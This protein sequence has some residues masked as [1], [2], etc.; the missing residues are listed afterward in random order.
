M[1][2]L[3]ADQ[4]QLF[5][6]LSLPLWPL[7]SDDLQAGIYRGSRANAL[8][9]RY[10]EANP[11][12]VSNLLVPDCDHPDALMR[13]VWDRHDWL[14]TA[15]VEDPPTAMHTPCGHYASRSP[16]PST[17]AASPSPTPQPSPRAH[18]ARSMATRA[19]PD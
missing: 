12:A 17:P 15:V 6:Q 8:A 10:I 18:A 3:Q 19:T 5:E 16:A 9:T 11:H 4:A 2:A 7:A 1:G 13:A 14:P